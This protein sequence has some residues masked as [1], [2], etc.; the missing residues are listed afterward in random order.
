[1]RAVTVRGYCQSN[2]DRSTTQLKGPHII[3]TSLCLSQTSKQSEQ[4]ISVEGKGTCTYSSI[5]CSTH[6]LCGI[7]AC[8]ITNCCK[9]LHRI[10]FYSTVYYTHVNII[11]MFKASKNKCAVCEKPVRLTVA[12][13]EVHGKVNSHYS[14]DMLAYCL[15]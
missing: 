5:A 3:Y 6:R 14:N 12:S 1:M 15:M 2:V 10:S 13:I 4:M 7:R 11:E 8:G 9:T